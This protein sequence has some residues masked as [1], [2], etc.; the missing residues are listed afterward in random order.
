MRNEECKRFLNIIRRII[1]AKKQEKLDKR[2]KRIVAPNGML[3]IAHCGYCAEIRYLYDIYNV[4][5]NTKFYCLE[6]LQNEG[7]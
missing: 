7:T 4:N 5:Q 6:E 3:Y 1:G 2:K